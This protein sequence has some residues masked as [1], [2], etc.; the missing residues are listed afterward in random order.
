MKNYQEFWAG[1]APLALHS[2]FRGKDLN[3]LAEKL[4]EPIYWTYKFMLDIITDGS[5]VRDAGC[6]LNTRR[7][8]LKISFI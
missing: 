2:P 1:D 6:L 8:L 7:W 4:R 3:H 5:L